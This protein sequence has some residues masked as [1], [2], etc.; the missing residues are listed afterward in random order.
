M[1]WVKE[2]IGASGDFRF[3]SIHTAHG[4]IDDM[5]LMKTVNISLQRIV[6]LVG[7]SMA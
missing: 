4:D 7:G 1:N 3:V 5:I 6:L 2:H